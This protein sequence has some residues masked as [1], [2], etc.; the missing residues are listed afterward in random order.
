MRKIPANNVMLDRTGL[1]L[2]SEDV[3]EVRDSKW[4]ACW[5]RSANWQGTKSARP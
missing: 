2:P 5:A 4:A 3:Y 1:Q